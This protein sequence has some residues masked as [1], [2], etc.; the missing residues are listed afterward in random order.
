M[1]R[2]ATLVIAFLC[3]LILAAGVGLPAQANP[4]LEALSAASVKS[5]D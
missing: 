4:T 3:S 1:Q 5:A 2:A